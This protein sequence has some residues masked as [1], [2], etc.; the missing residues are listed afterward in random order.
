MKKTILI[1]RNRIIF[2]L[3]A[4]AALMAAQSSQ[5]LT[6]LDG[7]GNVWTYVGDFQVDS[8]P[9][10]ESNPLCYTGI[11]AADLVFGA[12]AAGEEYAISVDGD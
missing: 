10:W 2:G 6:A 12:P 1:N 7:D 9:Y 3:F 4:S 8:G 5:A 11:Q